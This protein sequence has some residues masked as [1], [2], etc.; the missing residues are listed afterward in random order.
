VVFDPK[1][2]LEAPLVQSLLNSN[3]FSQ[4][5]KPNLA[6]LAQRYTSHIKFLSLRQKV[7]SETS[8]NTCKGKADQV[9][10]G[11]AFPY[12]YRHQTQSIEA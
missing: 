3:I 10:I 6:F 11:F 8:S 4:T 12:F 2:V 1:F 9:D 7:V 5:I